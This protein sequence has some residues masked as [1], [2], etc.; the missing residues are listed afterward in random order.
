MIR[1]LL[2][3]FGIRDFEVCQ[4]C[5]TLKQQLD[6]ERS[7][8]KQLTDTLLAILSPK[9]VEAAPV[10]INQIN[11]SALL[12]S[13]RKAALEERDR[14][15]AK[16]LKESRNLARPDNFI[17]HSSVDPADSSDSISSISKLEEE[18]GIAEEKTN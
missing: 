9:V 11:Q 15:E 18:L 13:R 2:R 6:F 7:E 17:R 10:E 16:T 8:K 5:E 1:L 3:L 14:I 12:F 4:S